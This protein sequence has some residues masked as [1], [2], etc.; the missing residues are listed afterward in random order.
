MILSKGSIAGG[1]AAPPETWQGPTWLWIWDRWTSRSWL[2][3]PSEY[4]RCRI[5]VF[6]NMLQH[7]DRS[8]DS[9]GQGRV[10]KAALVLACPAIQDAQLRDS[11]LGDLYQGGNGVYVIYIAACNRLEYGLF[12]TKETYL[13]FACINSGQCLRIWMESW[14]TT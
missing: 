12:P 7:Q 8:D 2:L 14:T 9:R 5:P 13:P 4:K 10:P 3:K 11:E 1:S 6:N